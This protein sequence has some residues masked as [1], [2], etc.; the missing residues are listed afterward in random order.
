MTFQLIYFSF[1]S[2]FHILKRIFQDYKNEKVVILD[3]SL[4][5]KIYLFGK[6]KVDVSINVFPGPP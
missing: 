4:H 2:S 3:G 6:I 5:F 1:F